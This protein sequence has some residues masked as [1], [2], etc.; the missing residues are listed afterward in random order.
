MFEHS[1]NL[2]NFDFSTS[3]PPSSSSTPLSDHVTDRS[4]GPP[5]MWS[6]PRLSRH[7]TWT[8]PLDLVVAQQIARNSIS[9]VRQSPNVWFRALDRTRQACSTLTGGSRGLARTS[10]AACTLFAL[11]V[12]VFCTFCFKIF[13][14]PPPTQQIYPLAQRASE[15]S[16]L[17]VEWYSTCTRH[18]SELVL[19]KHSTSIEAC[20]RQA[21]EI[22]W[23]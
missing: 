2:A 6:I 15:T 18:Q 20:T 10:S 17:I 7:V 11:H 23:S 3:P 9:V 1:Q 13:D 5:Q 4:P 8:P 16:I 12:T 21:L 19:D 14:Y 22:N